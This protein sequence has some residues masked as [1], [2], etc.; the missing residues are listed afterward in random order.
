MT[1]QNMSAQQATQDLAHTIGSLQSPTT[2][3]TQEMAQL[4]LNS[5]TVA[6]QLGSKGLTGTIGELTTAITTH[7]G[8]SGQ[9]IMSAFNKSTAAGQDAQIML[10]QL[11][12]SIQG[13]A[14]A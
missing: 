3:Q 6:S 2:V 8:P 10:N 1:A 5:Q 13:V 11:P 7:M 4:G 14:K 12:A 9:V